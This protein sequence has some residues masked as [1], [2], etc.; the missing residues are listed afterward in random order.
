MLRMQ[1][2]PVTKA[3]P[4]SPPSKSPPP[5][6]P[7]ILPKASESTKPSEVPKPANLRKEPPVIVSAGPETPPDLG[8]GGAQHKAMQKRLKTEAE[9]LG[10]LATIEKEIPNGSVDLLLEKGGVSIACEI[11]V[12]TTIDHEFGNVEKCLKAGFTR[13]AVICQGDER[14]S[15]IQI[16]VKSSLGGE[17]SSRVDYFQPDDFIA[18]LRGFAA[19]TP[20]SEKPSGTTVIRRG[21]KVVRKT[22]TVSEEERRQREEVILKQ[23][24]GVMA[25]KSPST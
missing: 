20:V 15:R 21:R 1:A 10:F 11:S 22:A 7:P 3:K 25:H 6:Q 8:K 19:V 23:I 4:A 17:A 13:V 18:H 24:A 5:E 9:A 2:E 12:T 16:A 14:L